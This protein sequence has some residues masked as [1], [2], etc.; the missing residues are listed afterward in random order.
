MTLCLWDLYSVEPVYLGITT[1][2]T[3]GVQ[4]P[5]GAGDFSLLHR[6]DTGTG[7]YPASYAV[8]A[9][10]LSPRV[11]RRRREADHSPPSSIEVNNVG[12]IPPLPHTSS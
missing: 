10:A 9:G 4:F 12:A 5:A 8:G 6:V 1:S 2:W 3:A 7:A 11:K